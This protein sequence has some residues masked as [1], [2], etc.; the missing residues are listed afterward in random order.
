MSIQAHADAILARLRATANLTVY[1][2]PDS[3][4]QVPAGAEPPY[5][6][7]HI[8]TRYDLGP[9]L[10]MES[11]RAVT[12]VT[13]HCVGGNAIAARAVAQLVSGALLDF[14]PTIAGRTCWPIRQDP[15]DNPP[16]PDE[17]TGQLVMDLVA[18]Y[19]LETLPG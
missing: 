18:Q 11:G 9:S 5:V 16:R 15:V 14:V 17:S 6:S 13:C 10:A 19:R 12:T 1:P 3:P 2:E 4:A 8:T 7:V